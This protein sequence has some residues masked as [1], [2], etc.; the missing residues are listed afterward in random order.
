LSDRKL[1]L[2]RATIEHI[3]VARSTPTE[4]QPRGVCLGNGNDDNEVCMTVRECSLTVHSRN[5]GEEA[6]EIA[7]EAGKRARR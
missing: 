6:K 5:R 1:K 3:V 4:E 2:S 7:R